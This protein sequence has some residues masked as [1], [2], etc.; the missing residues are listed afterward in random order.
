MFDFLIPV[1]HAATT[2]AAAPKSPMGN[3]VFLLVIFAAIM[4]FLMWRPQSK[5]AKQQREMLSAIKAGDEVITSGGIIA[6]VVKVEEQFMTADIAA[7]TTVKLQK[8]AVSMVL[9]KGTMKAKGT[10]PVSKKK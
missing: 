9:P 10:S 7:G 4:Y 1:A 3:M 6:K 8:N 2:G 5:R